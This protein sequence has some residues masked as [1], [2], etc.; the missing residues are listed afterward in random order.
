MAASTFQATLNATCQ[1]TVHALPVWSHESLWHVTSCLSV[2]SQVQFSTALTMISSP[3]RYTKYNQ[4]FMAIEKI[5]RAT[6]LQKVKS[7]V[8]AEIS[9]RGYSDEDIDF[10]FEADDLHMQAEE[11]VNNLFDSIASTRTDGEAAQNKVALSSWH[12]RSL[13]DASKEGWSIEIHE[14]M[15]NEALE[16][17]LESDWL[18]C[19]ELDWLFLELKFYGEYLENYKVFDVN[20]NGIF[21]SMVRMLNPSRSIKIP[22]GALGLLWAITK[23]L[24]WLVITVVVFSVHTALG[25]VWLGLTGY[26]LWPKYRLRSRAVK[27]LQ[28][29]LQIY[30]S[31]NTSA[32]SWTNIDRLLSEAQSKYG[33]AFDSRLMSLVD[34]RL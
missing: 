14:F 21:G 30:N 1:H 5:D 10:D 18:W 32:V 33:V 3:V 34:K 25:V 31:V 20:F 11:M 28:T 27:I 7:L 12:H 23:W 4:S 15:L 29:S 13:Y 26:V 19:K 6:L 9:K 24:V 22:L 17:Y 16:Y 2:V 8:D